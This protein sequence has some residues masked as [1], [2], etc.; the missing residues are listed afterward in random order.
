[1]Q[2]PYLIPLQPTPQILSIALAGVTY[3]LTIYWNAQN[4]SWTID[5][6][7]SSGNPILTGIP[8]VTGCDLL[9]QFEYL[10]F[11]G[12]LVAQTANGTDAI[13]TFTNLGSNGNLYFLLETGEV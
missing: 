11:G 4:N 9:G 8:M 10:N 1:M 6:A 13:P 7:D 12:E 2:T 5:I 3:Q